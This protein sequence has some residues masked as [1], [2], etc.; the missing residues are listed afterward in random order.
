[1]FEGGRD[2]HGWEPS[3]GAERWESIG[4]A[5]ELADVG[6]LRV[7]EAGVDACCCFDGEGVG[8]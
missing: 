4:D 8:D 1:M 6:K 3:P 5:A 2:G 7:D